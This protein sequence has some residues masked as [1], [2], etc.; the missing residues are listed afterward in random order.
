MCTKIKVVAVVKEIE[1]VGEFI[2]FIN[3][4]LEKHNI[5]FTMKDI[6]FNE[7]VNTVYGVDCLCKVDIPATLKK[8]KMDYFF[9]GIDYLL[10]EDAFTL[11]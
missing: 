7:D 11:C 8:L 1:T 6:V 9:T 5:D 4:R 3:N 10:G 2:E